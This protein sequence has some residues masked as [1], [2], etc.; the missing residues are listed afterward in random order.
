MQAMTAAIGKYQNAAQNK[1]DRKP[2]IKV[3]FDAFFKSLLLLVIIIRIIRITHCFAVK[4][5]TLN[6]N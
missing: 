1:K 3:L 2:I 4:K 6:I 5:M